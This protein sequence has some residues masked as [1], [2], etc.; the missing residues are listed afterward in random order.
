MLAQPSP[1]SAASCNGVPAGRSADAFSV[2][3]RPKEGFQGRAF[4]ID[5]DGELTAIR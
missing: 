1:K 3:A 2:V 4:G 5:A